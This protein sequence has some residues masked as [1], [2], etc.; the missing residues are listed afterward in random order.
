MR[1]AS[2]A[3]WRSKVPESGTTFSQNCL[4]IRDQFIRSYITHYRNQAKM[5]KEIRRIK[6]E[7]DDQ[8]RAILEAA[9]MPATVNVTQVATQLQQNSQ[10]VHNI[11]NVVKK[12]WILFCWMDV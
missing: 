10:I 2:S 5:Q 9:K 4:L 6:Q 8:W 7:R 1:D 3:F 11:E 12:E